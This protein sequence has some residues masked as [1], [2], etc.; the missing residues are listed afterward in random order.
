MAIFK[1]FILNMLKSSD[2]SL[3][4]TSHSIIPDSREKF[5]SDLN[6]YVVN[7]LTIMFTFLFFGNILDNTINHKHLNTTCTLVL[8]TFL[9]FFGAISFAEK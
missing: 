2:S 7:N 5:I 6:R 9:T 1:Y 3:R 8:A 4:M